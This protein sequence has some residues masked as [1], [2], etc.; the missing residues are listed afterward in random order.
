MKGYKFLRV[1][2]PSN[3]NVRL[4]VLTNELKARDQRIIK[5]EKRLEEEHSKRQSL[6]KQLTSDMEH[7]KTTLENQIE[8]VTK[9]YRELEQVKTKQERLRKLGLLGKIEKREKEEPKS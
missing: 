9:L 7:M 6:E 5:L 1:F 3:V 8:Q 2:Q 4:E